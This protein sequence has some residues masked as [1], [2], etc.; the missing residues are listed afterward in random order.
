MTSFLSYS[1]TNVIEGETTLSAANKINGRFAD[2]L[3]WYPAVSGGS[4]YQALLLNA[5][6]TGFTYSH[7]FRSNVALN[8]DAGNG[9]VGQVLQSD[10]D[11]TTSWATGTLTDGD[12]GDVTVSVGGTVWNIDNNT[13]TNAKMA[14]N[15][16]DTAEIVANAVT[17][18]KIADSNVTTAK[19]A[20]DNVTFAKL[21]NITGPVLLG[22]YTASSGDASAM[23]VSADSGHIYLDS[24]SRIRMGGARTHLIGYSHN[25]MAAGD[26]TN[27]VNSIAETKID[28]D[29]QVVLLDRNMSAW[30]TIPA[31]TLVQ[32]STF[33]VTAVA[34]YTTT[35]TPTM[36]FRVKL[37]T[38][39]VLDT[40]AVTMPVANMS[41]LMECSG[42]FTL[43]G[44]SSVAKSIGN[45]AIKLNNE[46]GFLA[47][48]LT[49]AIR[50]PVTVDTTVNQDLHLFFQWGTANASNSA[51]FT[52]VIVERLY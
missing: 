36:A 26:Q 45:C 42:I 7:V 27:V 49:G 34:H 21:E 52:N 40:T 32:G 41:G 46:L 15:A 51:F 20:D 43:T 29:L 25:G 2:I 1:K 24:S 22:R 39:V 13:I 17:T 31:N 4:Q 5:G 18:A 3:S 16:I 35:G 48:N 44:A 9:T 12:K 47:Y 14:D 38:T 50:A 23:S 33:R 30:P 11:G 6:K 10:G 19:I 28:E 37:G 8:H